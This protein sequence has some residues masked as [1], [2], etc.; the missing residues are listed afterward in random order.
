MPDA[1]SLAKGLMA[2]EPAMRAYEPSWRDRMA[3]ALMGDGRASPARSQVV[4]G[5]LGSRGLGSTGLSAIDATPAGAILDIQQAGQQGDKAGMALA[6]AGMVPMAKISNKLPLYGSKITDFIKTKEQHAA[7]L[8]AVQK[9]I[10]ERSGNGANAQAAWEMVKSWNKLTPDDVAGV[11]IKHNIPFKVERSASLTD[12]HGPSNSVYFHFQNSNGEPA[13]FRLSDHDYVAGLGNDY[14]YSDPLQKIEN[15]ILEK[16]S[17]NYSDDAL[18]AYREH[19]QAQNEISPYNEE[20]WRLSDMRA[21]SL[22]SENSKRYQ[23]S[24]RKGGTVAD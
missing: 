16:T 4:M 17:K 5:L 21:E 9:Y 24:I 14:R 7:H 3:A 20:L 11:F 6:A 23:K 2:D 12:R 10:D 1:Q 18:R 19:I 22:P 13:T 8:S 15:D